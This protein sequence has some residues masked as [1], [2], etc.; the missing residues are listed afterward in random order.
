MD[1][2]AQYAFLNFFFFGLNPVQ[3]AYVHLFNER[4]RWDDFN[5]WEELSYECRANCL[6]DELS[7]IPIDVS[8]V[9]YSDS[10]Q[11]GKPSHTILLRSSRGK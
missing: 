3:Q 9:K 11:R 4:G 2:V 6:W 7:V 5:L 8:P 1:T 10:D